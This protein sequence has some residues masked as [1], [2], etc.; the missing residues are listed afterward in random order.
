MG[1]LAGTA[2]EGIEV[3]IATGPGGDDDFDALYGGAGQTPHAAAYEPWGPFNPQVHKLQQPGD[4]RPPRP[5]APPSTP[6]GA[7][8]SPTRART[9][10]RY[11]R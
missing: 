8:S 4:P 7:R 3:V 9:I 11:L 1:G 2:I 5:P 6:P 10:F